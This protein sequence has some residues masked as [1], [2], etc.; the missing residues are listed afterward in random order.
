M[1]QAG[2]IYEQSLEGRPQT[3]TAADDDLRPALTE[4]RQPGQKAPFLSG[5]SRVASATSNK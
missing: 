1:G 4:R 3:E 2:I 5:P